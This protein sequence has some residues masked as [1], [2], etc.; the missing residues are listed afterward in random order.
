MFTLTPSSP[1]QC[2]GTGR[3]RRTALAELAVA[4]G[5][6]AEELNISTDG[7]PAPGTVYVSLLET[8]P[9][10]ARVIRSGRINLHNVDPALDA[11]AALVEG[12]V[13]YLLGTTPRGL[14]QAVY[15]LRGQLERGEPLVEGWGVEGIFRV[16]QRLF[17]PRLQ[18]WPG[19]RADI[20][21]LSL[22]G[23]SHCLVSHD[24]QGDLRHLQ[25]YVTSPLFPEAVDPEQ[26]AA[27]HAGLRQLVDWCADYGLENA[28]WLT[29]LPCQGGPWTP[30]PDRARFLTRYAPEVFSDSG[31][32]EGQVLCFSHP[33]VQAYYRDLLA[34]FFA[35]FPEI[36]TIFLFGLD[37]SGE[38]CDPDSCP[39]C[40]GMSRFAQRDRFIR[41]LIEE[42]GKVRPGLR[43][44]TTGWEWDH[45][46]AEFLARQAALPAESGV[47]LAAQKDGWQPERQAH[48]FLR[49][50]RATCRR[51]GQLF[52]GYDNLQWGD[53]T[54][55]F[56]GDIQDYPLGIGAKLQR[57]FDLGVDGVFDHW[58]GWSEELSCNAMA[59]RAFL[60]NPLAEPT[61]I[62]ARIAREQFGTAAGAAVLR[63]WQSLERAQAILSNACTWSP[64]QWPGWYRGRDYPPLPAAFAL[65]REKLLSTGEPAKAAQGLVYN[66]G[67]FAERLQAVADTWAAATPYYLQA[68][69]AMAAAEELAT[70]E[71]VGYAWWWTGSAPSPT[72]REHVRRQ[73]RY[74]DSMALAGRE[75]GLHFGLFALWEREGEAGFAAQAAPLLAE[76]RAA[77]LA[78]ADYFAR[79]APAP[80]IRE[81]PARYREKA[82]A[83]AAYLAG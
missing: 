65:Q 81:W 59:C 38:F 48:D 74:L 1:I 10:I 53:D 32:Y 16:L 42:G 78:A 52:I 62:C 66:A 55:H 27:N 76:D 43:V 40:K 8:R 72:R 50:V 25:G 58:G 57:W 9:E 12:G 37:S 49:A 69:A 80:S 20:R 11:Y 44:L 60:L 67:E 17:H 34:R 24:W 7:P 79:L 6:S 23:A 36:G 35:E 14:L 19:E 83:I 77:C 26:V 73:R 21:Y 75:I 4:L 31:T 15:E 51:R 64:W 41:F 3:V 45:D 71:P 70:E 47:Y 30:A 63:A 22:L 5:V 39:R 54:V 29:E 56:I 13:L 2:P 82:A 68:I 18:G 28:L 33:Q 46:G 61:A